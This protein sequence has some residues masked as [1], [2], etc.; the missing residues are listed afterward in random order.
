MGDTQG[1]CQNF[2]LRRIAGPLRHK[3]QISLLSITEVASPTEKRRSGCDKRF[4]TS[5]PTLQTWFWWQ[6]NSRTNSEDELKQ[7][8]PAFHLDYCD[9]Q[10]Q[11]D[12]LCVPVG[13]RT[14]G[15]VRRPTWSPVIVFW[16]TTGNQQAKERSSIRTKSQTCWNTWAAEIHGTSQPEGVGSGMSSSMT[17]KISDQA[18]SLQRQW[19]TWWSHTPALLELHASM[20]CS[21]QSATIVIFFSQYHFCCFLYPLSSYFYPPSPPQLFST[22]PPRLFS[23]YPILTQSVSAFFILPSHTP[24]QGVTAAL[25]WRF[26]LLTQNENFEQR[27]PVEISG[28]QWHAG[29]ENMPSRSA[30]HWSLQLDRP[31][32]VEQCLHT[33]G[34]KLV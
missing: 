30:W 3:Q 19:E 22:L 10:S 29:S 26:V 4:C 32:T 34:Y 23:T 27:E 21:H 8:V 1:S 7:L 17:T 16:T 13:H 24:F 12:R 14:K 11:K 18:A 25:N 15:N 9:N 6:G 20:P 33:S 5:S 2:L 28:W 31:C